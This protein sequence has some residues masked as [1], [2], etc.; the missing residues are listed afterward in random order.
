MD[1]AKQLGFPKRAAVAALAVATCALC[2]AGGLRPFSAAP[3][4]FDPKGG[5][6][7]GIAASEDALYVAQM[8]HLVKLDWTGKVLAS[9]GVQSRT[10]SEAAT[11]ASRASVGLNA[12]LSAQAT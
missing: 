4:A 6:I 5:H 10:N 8:T 11:N 2:A 1:M 3:G 9:R 7:Q 12:T